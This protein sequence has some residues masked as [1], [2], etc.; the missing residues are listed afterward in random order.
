MEQIFVHIFRFAVFYGWIWIH[1]VMRGIFGP[2][3]F[4][5]M[6]NAGGMLFC[7]LHAENLVR[8]CDLC[9]KK[10]VRR[11]SADMQMDLNGISVWIRF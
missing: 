11:I 5:K 6:G 9:R 4:R 8:I 2:S 7:T 10:Y 3:E 1:D